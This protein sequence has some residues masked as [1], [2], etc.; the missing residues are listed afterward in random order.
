MSMVSRAALRLE[1]S[2]AGILGGLVTTSITV[3]E[4]WETGRARLKRVGAYRTA[5]AAFGI[6]AGTGARL[7][8]LP[9]TS[10]LPKV[11]HT[12]IPISFC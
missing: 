7:S 6:V 9:Q 10:P 12:Y 11:E 4:R 3:K 5:T 8:K 1:S 2:T